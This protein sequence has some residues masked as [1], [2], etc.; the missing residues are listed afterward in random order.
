MDCITS[1]NVHELEF[2]DLFRQRLQEQIS[3]IRVINKGS[4]KVTTFVS[5][6]GVIFI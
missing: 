6:M 2:L 1:V 3:L 4:V 5:V